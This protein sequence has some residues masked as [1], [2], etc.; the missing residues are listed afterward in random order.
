MTTIENTTTEHDSGEFRSGGTTG[1]GFV[2]T[3]GGVRTEVTYSDIDGLALFEGDI[4]L[5]ETVGQE[6]VI[7]TGAGHRW[8]GAVVPFEVDPNLPNPQRVTDA[9]AHYGALTPVRFVPR[10]GQSDYVRFIPDTGS[11]SRVGRQGGRQDIRIAAG[12]PTGTVIHEMGHA[13]GLWH[14]QSREDRNALITVNFAN[15]A[16]GDQHNFQQHINDG[17]DTGGYDFGSIMHYPATA[18]STNG[19]PT[20]VPK[21]PLP[22][23]V[24]MGQRNGLSVG[25]RLAIQAMYGGW[26]PDWFALPGGHIFD[27][28]KQKI[29]AVSRGRTNLDLFVLGFDNKAYTHFWNGR[30][31]GDW[32]ALPGRHIFDHATQRIAAVSRGPNNLDLFVI[33]FDNKVYTH[34]WNGQWNSDWFALPGQHIFNNRTQHIAAVSRTPNHLDLFVIGFDN[35]VYTTF[36]TAQGGWSRDWFPL[37]GRHTFD[38]TTQKIAAVSRGPNNLDLFVIGFDNKVYTHFWNGQWNSDWFALPGGHT[39]DNKTQ[40]VAAVSRGAGNL[41]LFVLGFD[42]K[43]YTHFWNGRWNND[44]FP[45]PGRHVFD[46]KKQRLSVVSRGPNNLDLFVIGFD[47]RGYT[48]FWNGAWAADWFPLPGGHIFDNQTQQ[49]AAV[50]RGPSNLDLFVLGFD[51][52]GYTHFW[53]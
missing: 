43:A 26:A 27:N 8:P 36:W 2:E 35:R 47:N 20:I 33:G 13:I 46:N 51:N 25:D 4:V 48:H 15:I 50:S 31:N 7:V 40:H 44:W 12:A 24:V 39:F 16:S 21:V 38:H 32:F 23:G 6:G 9:V 3:P 41:D 49:I 1:T 22:P 37:P 52:R 19:Q 18:F 53:S 5:G 34:F 10:N 45:L 29:S 17:D 30:W 28:K 11:S 42:N 14:E